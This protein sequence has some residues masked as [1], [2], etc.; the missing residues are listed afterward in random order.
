MKYARRFCPRTRIERLGKV[1]RH[2]PNFTQM[3]LQGLPITLVFF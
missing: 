1:T 3:F 2:P